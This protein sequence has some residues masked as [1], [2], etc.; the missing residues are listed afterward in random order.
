M[1]LS[2][3]VLK[4]LTKLNYDLFLP[5]ADIEVDGSL[6]GVSAR[7]EKRA[8]LPSVSEL[9]RMFDKVNDKYFEGRL[10]RPRISYSD[11]MLIAGSFASDKNELRIGKKYHEIFRD[12]I[13][14]TLKHE[15]IHIVHPRHDKGFK[16][17]AEEIGASL[18][19]R[20]HPQ[21]R[22]HYKYLYVCPN[23]GKEYPRRKRIRMASCG[24]CTKGPDFDPAFKLKPV[25]CRENARDD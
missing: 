11:R 9:Y 15:M 14:D 17:V 12:E 21:L 16:A 2:R 18:R 3:R 19:A 8:P 13:E 24:V 10:P 25:K 1:G 23:C 7:T 5:P 20:T 4:V 22:G 6:P